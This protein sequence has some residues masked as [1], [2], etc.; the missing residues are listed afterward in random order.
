MV[1]REELKNYVYGLSKAE[2][3]ERLLDALM[4]L[5]NSYKGRYW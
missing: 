1:H 2:L 5:E 3:R 4:E